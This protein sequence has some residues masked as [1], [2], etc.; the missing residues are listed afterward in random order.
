VSDAA[1]VASTTSDPNSANNTA[2]AVVAIGRTADLSLTDSAS[3]ASVVQGQDV[4]FTL[5]AADGGPS[6]APSTVITDVL[7]GGLS[8]VSASAGCTNSSGTVTCVAGSLADGADAADTVVVKATQVGSPVD[9]ATVTSGAVDPDTSNNTA[10]AAVTVGPAVDLAITDVAPA[11]V[12]A[13]GNLDYAITAANNGPSAGTGVSWSDV[14]PAGE[15]FASVTTPA[16]WSCTRPAV[17]VNGTVTCSHAAAYPDGASD[18]FDLSAKVGFGLADQTVID[19]VSVGGNESDPDPSNSTASASATVGPAADVSLTDSP[20]PA[21]AAKGEDVTYTLV[22]ANAG[23]DTATGVVVTDTLPAGV[24]FASA[25]A[26]CVNSLGV[27]TCSLGSVADGS[28]RTVTIVVQAVALGDQVDSADLSADQPDPDVS[29][30]SANAGVTV[31]PAVD[32]AITDTG[33]ATSA[34][35]AAGAAATHTLTVTDDGPDNATGVTVTDTLPAGLSFVSATADQGTCSDTGPAVSCSLGVLANGSSTTITIVA[36]ASF[37]SAGQTLVDSA[38]VTGNEF[39]PNQT[40]NRSSTSSTVGPAA[41]VSLTDTADHANRSQQQDITYSLSYVNDG[42]S[43]AH[44]VIVIDALPA[45]A[46]FKSV[47]D[48]DCVASG[49]VVTCDEGTI[50]SGASG[51]IQLV[52]SADQLGVLHDAATVSANEPDPDTSN[53]SAAA[54]VTDGPTADLTLTTTTSTPNVVADGLITYTLAVQNAGPSAAHNVVIT[55]RLPGGESFIDATVPGGG[56]AENSSTVTCTIAELDVG[57]T[58][59]VTLDARAGAALTDSTVINTATIGADEGGTNPPASQTSSVPVNVG[60]ATQLPV[61]KT[62]PPAPAAARCPRP[63]GRLGGQALGPLALG[64]TRA[65]AR[66][67]MPRFNI[68]TNE[69]DNFCLYGGWGIRTGYPSGQLLRSISTAGRAAVSGRVV[70]A[71]TANP[72]YVLRGVRPGETQYA[73]TKALRFGRA[74]HVGLNYWYMVPNGSATAV[75]KVHGGIVQEIGIADG[76]LTKSDKARVTFIN[77]FF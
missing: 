41:D 5:T 39:D 75:L 71:L 47:N 43:T 30:N 29:D 63:T 72:Y 3:P 37:S 65:R 38:S 19:D 49:G 77:S 4:S 76:K 20:D 10:S 34:T 18:A 62:A 11:T 1:T 61:V 51:T 67:T 44:N 55:D 13:G 32:L 45:G 53:N 24:S 54:D 2:T 70:L 35:S 42:P 36:T 48:A 23:P 46:T 21:S 52:A 59:A 73:A 56:C 28:S 26:G 27:V 69:F 25:S 12:T 33:P 60:P 16:G 8:F 15:T 68:T 31:G 14:L 17:G 66:K 9:A 58:A 64:M 22:A 6:D 74:M 7:P 50:V 57:A 40:N